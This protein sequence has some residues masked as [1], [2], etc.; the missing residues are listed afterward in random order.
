MQKFEEDTSG[1]FHPYEEISN[2]S[3]QHTLCVNACA[4]LTSNA[5]TKCTAAPPHTLT[6]ASMPHTHMLIQHHATYTEAAVN[7]VMVFGSSWNCKW[8]LLCFHIIVLCNL[9]PRLIIYGYP[10]RRSL[11]YQC[12]FDCSCSHSSPCQLYGFGHRPWH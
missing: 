12:Q 6:P 9:G 10:C 3:V 2:I 8:V 7:G 11:I 5:H 1:K 4:H